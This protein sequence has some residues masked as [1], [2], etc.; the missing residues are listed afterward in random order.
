MRIERE[1]LLKMARD[2]RP[3][4]ADRER[5]GHAREKGEKDYVTE[6]DLQV[7]SRV[8]EQ[9]HAWYP[10]VQ[11]LAE[12]KDRDVK[13]V[14]TGCLSERYHK[15]LSEEMPEVDM[16]FGVNDYDD[17]PGILLGETEKP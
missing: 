11:M 13:L 5:A 14:V 8:T 12:E 2:M 1:K 15:E 17:L 3:V 6:V 4:M 9:L 7:Q 10:Q 16:F